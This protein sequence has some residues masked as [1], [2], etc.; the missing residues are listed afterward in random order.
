MPQVVCHKPYQALCLSSYEFNFNYSKKGLHF[1]S[2]LMVTA[3]LEIGVVC[4][5]H[6][7]EMGDGF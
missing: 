1:Q 3:S 5:V 6:I 7:L 4:V 2:P